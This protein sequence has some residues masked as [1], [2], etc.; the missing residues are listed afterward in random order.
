MKPVYWPKASQKFN[1]YIN[2]EEMYELLFSIQ[3]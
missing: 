1:I 3:Q 2:E